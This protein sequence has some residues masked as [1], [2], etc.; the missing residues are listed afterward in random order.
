[1]SFL[2]PLDSAKQEQ[3]KQI[4]ERVTTNFVKFY[5][6]SFK[7][8]CIEEVKIKR[9]KEEKLR[10]REWKKKQRESD[11]S[12]VKDPPPRPRKGQEKKPKLSAKITYW[13]EVDSDVDPY[14]IYT[15]SASRGD[16]DV[17]VYK[18]YK[19]FKA[20]KSFAKKLKVEFPK[21]SS[22]FG[23]RNLD[24]DFIRHRVETLNKVL[25]ACVADE[26][27]SNSKEFLAFLHLGQK[28]EYLWAETFDR[29]Y[30][31]TRCYLWQWRRVYYET[32]E[33]AIARLVVEEVKDQV[34]PDVRAKLP[35][36]HAIRKQAIKVVFKTINAIVAPPVAAA[37]AACRKAADALKPTIQKTLEEAFGELV[38]VEN[39]VK[40][41]IQ[42]A[43]KAAFDPVVQAMR[44]LL[45]PMIGKVLPAV[46]GTISEV[47]S[48]DKKKHYYTSLLECVEKED[49][50]KMKEIEKDVADIRKTIQQKVEEN[51]QKA[52]EPVIGDFKSKVSVQALMSVFSPLEKLD[53]VLYYLLEFADPWNQFHVIRELIKHKKTIK[54]SPIEKVEELLDSEEWDIDY[55]AIWRSNCNI[56]WA[57]WRTAW[58][59]YYVL[60]SDA[61]NAAYDNFYKFTYKVA[62]INETAFKYKFSYKFGDYLS[63]RVKKGG[64]TAENWAKTVDECFLIGFHKALKYAAKQIQIV[65]TK[66]VKKLIAALVIDK[67]EKV[68][69]EGAATVLEPIQS[70]IIAPMDQIL[71]LGAMVTDVIKKTMNDVNEDIVSSF[72]PYL[73]T[74]IEQGKKNREMIKQLPP[75]TSTSSSST[76]SDK[77]E[78]A[79]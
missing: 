39:Q 58:E 53:R 46:T 9:A 16:E 62:K 11:S 67:I 14:I 65:V 52:V 63:D 4:V 26:T 49:E 23:K 61:G 50:D 37:Y 47:L 6:L 60:P 45:T 43:L 33:E 38:K 71:D 66:R 10:L 78:V 73:A 69:L 72:H 31:R 13:S 17:T 56:K 5:A 28:K 70:M 76:S 22:T 2:N 7:E 48:P 40:D 64:V 18:R 15:V 20:I 54:N 36:V 55:W 8:V 59:M 74:V 19:Q 79:A 42:A 27:V 3:I 24:R 34:W 75:S 51:I 57:G 21:A 41:K 35:S 77:H 29:A 44:D 32:E 12:K 30:Y 68:L 1:M 25:E